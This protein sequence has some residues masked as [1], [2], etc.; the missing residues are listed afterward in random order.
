MK[1]I[2][3][4]IAL[5]GTITYLGNIINIGFTYAVSWQRMDPV[6]FMQGFE[7]T[8]LLL[9]PTVAVTLLPGLIGIIISII[10]N[11]EAVASKKHWKMALYATLISVAIT[12]IYHLPTNLSFIDQSYTPTTATSMLQVWIILHWV[13]ILLALVASVFAILGFA[14]SIELQ[15]SGEMNGTS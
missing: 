15:A 12:S 14:K 6:A 5:I 2:A 11:K 9:L 10:H 8:F 1:K 13:R 7:S 4:I 3:G